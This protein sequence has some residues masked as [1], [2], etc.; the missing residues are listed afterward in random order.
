MFADKDHFLYISLPAFFLCCCQ[1]GTEYTSSTIVRMN[2]ACDFPVSTTPTLNIQVTGNPIIF[3]IKEV[4][5]FVTLPLSQ[6]AGVNAH[7][8]PFVFVAGDYELFYFCCFG[9]GQGF[10]LDEALSMCF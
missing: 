3:I 6:C 9:P 5:R 4:I 2:H 8:Q 7:V 10:F 1:Q